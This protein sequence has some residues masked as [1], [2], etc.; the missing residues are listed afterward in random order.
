[1]YLEST[2]RLAF[3]FLTL[4]CDIKAIQ[5]KPE[6]YL[7]SVICLPKVK[8]LY[9][10]FF[11]SFCVHSISIVS[12]FLFFKLFSLFCFF[13][14]LISFKSGFF[15]HCFVNFGD[16]LLKSKKK[17]FLSLS[18][19]VKCCFYVCQDLCFSACPS[20]LKPGER[21]LVAPADTV[22]PCSA[23]SFFFERAATL[24]NVS[25]RGRATTRWG[26]LKKEEKEKKTTDPEGLLG[27]F[28]KK[29]HVHLNDCMS[30]RAVLT[31]PPTFLRKTRQVSTHS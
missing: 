4:S 17:C 10:S 9:G 29:P 26:K 14:R 11:V 28:K 12:G 5:L 3:F 16:F 2:A 19:L 7:S 30:R 24:K 18:Y 20:T 1:M 15:C 31:L 23:S 6:C 27:H 22:L 21:K 25:P 13:L 8:V